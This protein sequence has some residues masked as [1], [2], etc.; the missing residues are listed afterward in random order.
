M[1]E[2]S[3]QTSG[4]TIVF[5]VKIV[6]AFKTDMQGMEIDLTTWIYE[7]NRVNFTLTFPTSASRMR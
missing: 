6:G 7:P 1:R 2:T 3:V 4:G 5:T